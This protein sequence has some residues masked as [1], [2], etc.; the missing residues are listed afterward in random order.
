[1][2]GRVACPAAWDE[3]LGCCVLAD[4]RGEEVDERE[5]L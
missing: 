4:E 5:A 1:M 3:P 2:S